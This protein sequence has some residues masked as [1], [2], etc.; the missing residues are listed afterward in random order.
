MG[1]RER[2]RSTSQKRKANEKKSDDDGFRRQG[3]QRQRKT[4]SG[5]SQVN[6]EGVGEYIAPVEFYI[7]NTDKRTTEDTIS[8][9][10]K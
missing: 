4:A 9:V 8:K 6:I 3:R 7:G 10:L 5:T 2:S 1:I